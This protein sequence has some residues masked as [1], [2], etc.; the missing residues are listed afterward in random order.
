MIVRDEENCLAACLDSVKTFVDEMV[1][2]DTGSIDETVAIAEA[3]GARVEHL[4][5][6]GD[7]APARN[8][9]LDLVQGDWVLVLDADEQLLPG[10]KS[11][12]NK[13]MCMEDI[14]LV[15]LLRYE[16]GASM[17]PYSRVS[18]LFRRHPKIT[19]N[20]PYHSIVDDSVKAIL[21]EE[22]QWR[23]VDCVE[24][25][26]RHVGYRPELIQN[27]LKAKRL[28]EAMQSWLSKHPG[29]P[30]ACA[31]LGA[32]EVSEGNR[33]RGLQL[34]KEGLVK[35]ESSYASVN[36]RY[37]LLLHLGIALT[38]DD[39]NF[40][41]KTFREALQ[42][43]IDDRTSLGARL[44]L[45]ALLMNL[46]NFEEAIALTTL[47]T[48]HAPEVA[49]GWYNLGLMMRRGGFLG[50]AQAAYLRAIALKP[51]Y[52]EAHQNLGSAKFLA[53]EINEARK[54]FAKAVALLMSQ[55]R[56]K[57][58]DALKQKLVGIVNLNQSDS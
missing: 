29:D 53:G 48:K 31:K 19:W 23:I 13:L 30:Y 12:L 43:Q 22:T 49:L 16:E 26:L 3:A 7:F 55:G 11:Q 18:R 40:A 47:A 25:A 52:A 33:I 41:V 34:L 24:P 51:D 37:E 54:C 45:A 1:V 9:A 42:L 5:W 38:D 4:P 56:R 14:L 44:N 50:K 15:N 27:R 58:A 35:S 21:E 6:P 2:V 10:C 20:R 8:F 36:E 39:P 57:D 28:R 32:L 46:G 17:A